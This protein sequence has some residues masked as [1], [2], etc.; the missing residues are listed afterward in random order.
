MVYNSYSSQVNRV[1]DDDD[2]D[3]DGGVQVKQKSQKVLSI[4]GLRLRR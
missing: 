4:T 3:D 2:N 1:A